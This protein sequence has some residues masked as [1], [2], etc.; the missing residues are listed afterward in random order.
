M[1]F[2]ILYIKM[3]ILIIFIIFRIISSLIFPISFNNNEIPKKANDYTSYNIIMYQCDICYE[4]F[5]A[6]EDLLKH[7]E[8]YHPQEFEDIKSLSAEEKDSYFKRLLK[9]YVPPSY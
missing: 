5:L 2:R 9:K 7:L 1:T 6:R 8:Y 4:Y 3:N